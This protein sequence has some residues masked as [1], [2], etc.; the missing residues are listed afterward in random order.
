MLYCFVCCLLL[1]RGCFCF[2]LL[3]V[4]LLLLLS[5]VF[6][7]CLLVCCAFVFA[8]A[9]VF[10]VFLC[11]CCAVCWCVCSGVCWGAGMGNMGLPCANFKTCSAC[12]TAASVWQVILSVDDAISLVENVAKI[13]QKENTLQRVQVGQVVVV[14]DLHGQ[15]FDLLRIFDTTG[16]VSDSNPYL[17]NGDF[18]DRGAFSLEV[19]LSLFALK[20][21]FPGAVFMNRGNHEAADL[22]LRYGFAAEIRERYGMAGKR[23]FDA[24]AETFRWL[25]LAHVLNDEVT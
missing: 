8:F 3:S 19:I 10:V 2:L 13:L 24:F 22:N 20:L 11:I 5:V 15:F 16:K 17:F 25:P 9:V 6:F 4:A 23:L 18:V 12:S 14:G 21:R 7:V 1:S